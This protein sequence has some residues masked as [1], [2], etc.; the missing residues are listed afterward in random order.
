MPKGVGK[1]VRVTAIPWFCREHY[2]RILEMIPARQVTDLPDT[3][4]QWLADAIRVERELQAE[5]KLVYRA[6]IDPDEFE[7]WCRDL[8]NKPR[9]ADSL[10]QFAGFIAFRDDADLHATR[11]LK[12]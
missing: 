1:T 10:F 7:K 4:D 9:N 6:N 3:F 8:D 5:G 2:P 12:H 11:D